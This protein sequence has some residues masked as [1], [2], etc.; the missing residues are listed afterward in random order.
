MKTKQLIIFEN[1]EEL[2]AAAKHQSEK[3][4][5]NYSNST[6]LYFIARYFV[7]VYESRYG[8]IPISVWNEYRNAIDHFFRY[9]TSKNGKQKAHG[10]PRQLEKME[11]HLQRAALDILKILCHRTQEDIKKIKGSYPADVLQMVDNGIFYTNLLTDTRNA[12]RKFE[13]A[14]IYD[15]NLGNTASQDIDVLNK[16]LD[17]TFAFDEIKRSLINRADDIQKAV[18]KYKEISSKASNHST[19][20]HY[21]IHFTFYIF[22]TVFVFVASM[23]WEEALRPIFESIKGVIFK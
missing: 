8:E 9:L 20:K 14:K 2:I 19:I 7:S 16:Y 21:I 1:K 4:D 18:N 11:G 3:V 17:A 15:S 5:E 10:M 12:E 23:I 13:E 22:W 6:Y